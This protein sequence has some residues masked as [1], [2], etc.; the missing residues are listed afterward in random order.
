MKGPL[1]GPRGSPSL[2]PNMSHRP[3]NPMPNRSM[4]SI[5]T[6]ELN[7]S[8][9]PRDVPNPGQRQQGVGPIPRSE[10][11]Y[12]D[13]DWSKLYSWEVNSEL[14]ILNLFFYPGPPGPPLPR[15]ILPR[16]RGYMDRMVEYLIGDGPSNR[17]PCWKIHSSH[18]F[19]LW[20]FLIFIISLLYV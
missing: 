12:H 17:W 13:F 19:Q 11:F 6:D 14:F 16:E 4:S 20:D 7:G 10:T 15:P 2:T 3:L 1:A 18:I 9:A 8:F 5:G